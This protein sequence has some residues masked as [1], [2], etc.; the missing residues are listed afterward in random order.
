MFDNAVKAK[1]KINERKLSKYISPEW[2]AMESIETV[3][4][5][6][7]DIFSLGILFSDILM[8]KISENPVSIDDLE[9]LDLSEELL[10]LLDLMRADDP[11]ARFGIRDVKDIFDD[12]LRS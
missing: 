10:D 12:E 4:W 9:E 8:G 3:D 5:A 1:D 2:E 7:V 6:K 11:S